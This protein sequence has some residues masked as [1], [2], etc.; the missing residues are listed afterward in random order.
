MYSWKKYRVCANTQEISALLR[1]VL[2]R[3][4]RIVAERDIEIQTKIIWQTWQR[5]RV[6]K[7]ILL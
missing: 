2:K 5:Q 4:L 7:R 6:M 1:K 3:L